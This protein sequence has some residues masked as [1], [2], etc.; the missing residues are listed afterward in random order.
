ME[1]N[2]SSTFA[3][4]SPFRI[5]HFERMMSCGT[6][7][8][9]DFEDLTPL[10]PGPV[11]ALEIIQ[12][13][14]GRGLSDAEFGTERNCLGLEVLA[15]NEYAEGEEPTATHVTADR[16]NVVVF[17]GPLLTPV[18]LLRFPWDIDESTIKSRQ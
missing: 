4:A 16:S 9:R 6:C 14:L 5:V 13:L 12:E 18:M 2:S 3:C 10:N 11:D 8:N 1:R 15:D 7:I 17:L